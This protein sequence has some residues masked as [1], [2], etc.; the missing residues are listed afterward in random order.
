MNADFERCSTNEYD[1]ALDDDGRAV[2]R[3]FASSDCEMEQ[4]TENVACP[5]CMVHRARRPR[6]LALSDT[7][8]GEGSS[9]TCFATV[10]SQINL[11][12]SLVEVLLL[13]IFENVIMLTLMC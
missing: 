13:E 4:S 7:I 12:R 10:E 9:C 5:H 11:V 8:N 6:E 3:S 1:V 2:L